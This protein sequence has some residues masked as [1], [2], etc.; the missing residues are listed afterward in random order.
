MNH[1]HAGR[2]RYHMGVPGGIEQAHG[3]DGRPNE[4]YKALR[5]LAG[6]VAHPMAN[7]R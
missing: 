2:A 6:D 4:R 7:G 3:D 5:A 1:G